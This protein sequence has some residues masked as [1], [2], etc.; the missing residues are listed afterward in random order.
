M[1]SNSRRHRITKE[2]ITFATAALLCAMIATIAGCGDKN[3]KPTAAKTVASADYRYAC[4]GRILGRRRP[5]GQAFL[6]L[7][8][9]RGAAHLRCGKT[10]KV[11]ARRSGQHATQARHRRRSATRARPD[12]VSITRRRAGRGPKFHSAGAV[13]RAQRRCLNRRS[14]S[15]VSNSR[16]AVGKRRAKPISRRNTPW[17]LSPGR[18]SMPTFGHIQIRPSRIPSW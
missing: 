14:T 8:N 16:S 1:Y 11:A 9:S 12:E 4:A 17:V 2:S 6:P 3:E 13:W 18:V 7:Q 15:F 5:I 10:E